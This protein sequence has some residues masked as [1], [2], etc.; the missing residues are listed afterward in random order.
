MMVIG[1][2]ISSAREFKGGAGARPP[3]DGELL[4]PCLRRGVEPRTLRAARARPSAC[5]S[6]SSRRA[7]RRNRRS[8][9]PRRRAASTSDLRA[10]AM[11]DE[12][13]PITIERAAEK[14]HRGVRGLKAHCRKYGL[15]RRSGRTILFDER[16][17]D[18]LYRSL[19]CPSNSSSVT[20]PSTSGEPS[21]ASVATK[22]RARATARRQR[23]SGR[24]GKRNYSKNPSS[25]N[26]LSFPSNARP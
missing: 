17:F 19:P 13:W 20:A 6:R 23:R 2:S 16:D 21:E 4:R 3:V 25:A 7:P 22:L 24:S 12:A 1:G 11:I 9:G 10:A 15:G 14:L 26:V 5:P 8:S 18:A